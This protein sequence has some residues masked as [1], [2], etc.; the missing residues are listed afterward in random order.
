MTYRTLDKEASA[1]HIERHSRFIG[2][3]FPCTCEEDA[4]K[5][6]SEI[7]KLYPDAT[8]HVY[9]YNFR[10]NN[11]KRFNDDGEPQ[12]TAGIPVLDVIEK[13]G[14]IDILVVVVRYFGGILL[15]SGGLIRSYSQSAR[16]AIAESG[17]AEMGLCGVYEIAFGYAFLKRV[18]DL[19]ELYKGNISD[20]K[21]TENITTE[22]SMPLENVEL[23]GQKLN[24]IL[25]ENAAIIKKGEM[26]SKII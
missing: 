20:I 12:G 26:Y 3:A 19:L 13:Q 10:Q 24:D 1:G 17:I 22:F 18:K 2:Y 6:I 5:H 25:N 8:H 9:A 7:K 14:I 21:Y 23:F 15:G 11:V 16:L 4:L